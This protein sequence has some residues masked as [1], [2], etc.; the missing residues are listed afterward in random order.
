MSESRAWE[1]V[2]SRI[3]GDLLTGRLAIGDHLP[4]ERAL[5]AELSVGRSSVREAVRVLE[6]MGL[7][8]TATGSGPSS[9][10]V[11]VSRPA[12]GMASLMR[13]Q[14]AGRGFH[15]A[16]VVRTRVVLESEVVRDLAR[17]GERMDDARERLSEMDAADDTA[18][19][20]ALDAA[21]H[22]SLAETSGNGV[23]AAVMAG[24]RGSIESY[25]TE[26][27]ARID[28]WSAMARHL[29]S[30][31]RAILDAIEAGDADFAH[32]AV[33]AHIE[34]YYA[35]SNLIPVTKG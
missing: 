32:T 25:V 17:R 24:L 29:Q 22:Q 3:E 1:Q 13:L 16:H 33:T 8:R 26:G 20:L 14:V 10:A 21:F 9:G 30:E 11:I 19:F 12:G 6:V 15:V 4:S 2:L 34:G 18:V 5:A 7:I 35:A 28:D 27:A 23:I 31:H